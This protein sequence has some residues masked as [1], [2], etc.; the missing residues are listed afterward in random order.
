MSRT[1]RIGILWFFTSVCLIIVLLIKPFPQNVSYHRF[2]DSRMI[3]GVPNFF[4]VLSN[5]PFL[6]VGVYGFYALGTSRT[7]R[8]INA[9]YAVLF[10]GIFLTGIGSA[11]YHLAPNNRTLVFDRIPMTIVFMSFLS[12]TIAGWINIKIGARMLIPLVLLGIASVLWWY[13]TEQRGAGDIR[14]YGFIQFYPMLLIP[15]IFVFFANPHNNKGL[16]LLVWV[17]VWYVAAK[18]L[19]TFDSAIYQLTGF[20][21]G[22]SLKHI[23]AALATWY[24]VQFFEH[25]YAVDSNSF[26]RP[27]KP[28]L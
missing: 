7:F 12:A 8:I 17:I 11:Y 6:L 24:I 23:A 19:E 14:M 22:H 2:A 25:K 5:F 1:S 28:P 15:L 18:M 4:N 9:I 3:S 10:T 13:H 21:S 16:S 20:I 26:F 27:E